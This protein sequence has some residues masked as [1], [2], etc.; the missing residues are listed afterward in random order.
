M[1]DNPAVLSCGIYDVEGLLFVNFY[2]DEYP[3]P[4]RLHLPLNVET[5]M[6]NDNLVVYQPITYQRRNVGLLRMKFSTS[7]LDKQI[8][9]YLLFM[10][11]IMLISLF[12]ASVITV[13]MQKL[14]TGPINRLATAME[15]ISESS[16]YSV[17]LKTDLEDEIG[18]LYD[19]FNSMLDKIS[20]RE[21]ERDQAEEALRNA[22]SEIENSLAEITEL[23][24]DLRAFDYSVSNALRVPVRHIIGYAE[25]IQSLKDNEVNNKTKEYM[26]NVIRATTDL[27][28]LIDR[29]L[30]LSRATRE[31]LE[32]EQVNLSLLAHHITNRIK[33]DYNNDVDLRI[34]EDLFCTGD[35]RLLQLLLENLFDNA[36]K[37]STH[38]PRASVHFGK[39]TDRGLDVFHISD[40]GIGFKPERTN[41][42]FLPFHSFHTDST[43]TGVGLGLATAERIVHRHGGD[44]W[45][46]GRPGEG[47]TFYFTI[48]L[49]KAS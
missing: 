24:K 21:E 45:A 35:H 8:F 26:D 10:F 3:L 5:V 29:L 27:H 17:R 43:F 14:V 44:I 13:L 20:Q 1:K 11:V 22:H 41:N 31:E 16:D 32:F 30:R 37:F 46:E 6:G 40:N 33:K 39:M 4:N 12:V 34:E 49:D 25:V 23:N 18:I 19:G 47:A 2:R 42:L 36:F 9:D 28:L 15:V 48:R 38:R 7:Q